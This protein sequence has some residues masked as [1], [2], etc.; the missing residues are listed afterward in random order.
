MKGERLLLKT[1][2]LGLP[3]VVLLFWI[4]GSIN[5]W[6]YDIRDI[7]NNVNDYYLE[8]VPIEGQ[9]SV[10]ID[11]SNPKSNKGKVLYDDGDNQIYVFDVIV[12]DTT[13]YQ[14]YFRT[15]GKYNLHGA[16]LVSATEHNRVQGGFTYNFKANAYATYRGHTFKIYDSGTSGLNYS[17]GDDFGLY[18][19][20]NDTE[21]TIDISENPI[22]EVTL[23]KL[24][25]HKWGRK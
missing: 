20:P 4:T 16:T 24:T 1:I 10:T 12:G 14:V 6:F 15:S 7:D 17:D 3:F 5:L 21:V 18:L 13:Q 19:I 25:M 23:T 2:L 11:L 8:L 9:Y 22:I